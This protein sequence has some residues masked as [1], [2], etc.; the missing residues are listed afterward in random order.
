MIIGPHFVGK[1]QLNNNFYLSGS[2]FYSGL[3]EIISQRDIGTNATRERCHYWCYIK[4]EYA[5]QPVNSTLWQRR[6][7]DDVTIGLQCNAA[8][9]CVK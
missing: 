5:V 9:L 6:A 2:K 8:N 1:V 3:M 4:P 7:I